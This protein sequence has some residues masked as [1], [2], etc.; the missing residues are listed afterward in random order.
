MAYI[1][2]DIIQS[3]I[4]KYPGK[5]SGD[6]I[7]YQ[8]NPTNIVLILADGIGS[9][10]KA[11]IAAQ[12]CVSRIKTLLQSGFTL[13]E[14]FARLVNTMEEA[15]AK[16][17]PYTAFSLVRILQ[18]GIGT[19]LTYE[20]PTPIFVT[21]AYST[22]LKSRVYSINTAV[23]C[24]T[25]FELMKNEGIVLVTD[26]IT[27]AGLNQDYS[28]GLEL[29]GLNQFI[30]DQIKSGLKFRYLPKEITDNAFLINNKKMYDDLSAVI[31]FARKGRVVNI[32]T[33]PPKNEEKDAEA[34]KKFLELDGLK[35]ICGASTAKLV[36]REL[37]KNLVIDEK[38]TSSIS[39]PNYKIDGIDLVTEGIITLNQLYNIW[40]E[41]ESKLEK[42]NPVTD[43]YTLLKVADRIN[44]IVGTA[45]NPATEDITY[46][47]LG[48]LKRKKIIPLLLEKFNKEGKVVVVEEV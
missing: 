39:P 31:L 22:I 13:R 11:N 48:L 5:P 37:G 30:D 43:L 36:S 19:C 2:F 44:F 12:S 8:Y 15:K 7:Y 47:Q 23:V 38:F 27:Q 4:S 40:D 14:S 10:I 17:L 41:D 35:I 20:S 25:I 42:F 1:H 28:N 29:K 18:D 32:F 26:G 6:V 24:E 9:G 46:S 3:Q 21:K 33:G 34:V 16:D 45:D